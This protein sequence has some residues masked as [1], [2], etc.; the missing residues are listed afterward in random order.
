MLQDHQLLVR[1]LKDFGISSMGNG[2]ITIIGTII[3][4][5]QEWG[6]IQVHM[7]FDHAIEDIPGIP[8]EL[9]VPA[10][11]RNILKT[12]GK[13]EIERLYKLSLNGTIT[14]EQFESLKTKLEQ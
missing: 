9:V 8:S 7:A 12:R 11:F 6:P 14:R 10:E 1:K 2:Y 3:I 4:N 5:N 13:A